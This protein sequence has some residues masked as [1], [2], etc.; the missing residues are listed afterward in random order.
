MD[1]NKTYKRIIHSIKDNP[2][3]LTNK[4]SL[5]EEVLDRIPDKNEPLRKLMY[6]YVFGWTSVSWIRT[7]MATAALVL[8][9]FFIFQQAWFNHRI[10]NLEEQI[11]KTIDGLDKHESG[12]NLSEKILLN[13]I[14]TEDIDSITLSRKDFN[15]LMQSYIEMEKN[16]EYHNLEKQSFKDLIIQKK[17]SK[18]ITIEKSKSKL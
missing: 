2:P 14:S 7:S 10:N 9:G 3:V 5:M 8:F 12:L 16:L 18:D 4:D 15:K 11:V 1:T 6:H 13:L 17:M